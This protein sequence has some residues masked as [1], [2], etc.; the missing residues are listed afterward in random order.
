M[1]SYV[2]G[3]HNDR[4]EYHNAAAG[5]QYTENDNSAGK[6]VVTETTVDEVAWYFVER[7][8]TT[9]SDKPD[10]LH[11]FYN[12]KSQFVCGKE[13]DVKPVI[14][15]RSS[16]QEQIKEL[17]FQGSKVRVSN[18]DTQQSQGESIVIQVI[19]EMFTDGVLHKF[20]QTFVLARQAQGWYVLNDILRYLNDEEEQEAALAADEAT[21]AV[22]EEPVV[23][24]PQVE[25]PAEAPKELDTAEVYK[26]LESVLASEPTVEAPVTNGN[27][28]AP[29]AD[30]AEEAPVAE[31]KPEVSVT[32]EVAEQQVEEEIAKQEE[33]P[34]APAATPAV[35][36]PP[37]KAMP[38]AP[39][40]PAAPP[41][42]MTWASRAAAGISTAKPAPVVPAKAA[43][44][45]VQPRAAPPSATP[46]APAASATAPSAPAEKESAAQ[47][48]WQTAGSD[49]K[50]PRA[51]ATPA[52]KDS[53]TLG[54]I[55]NVTE[56]VNVDELK[57]TLSKYG[58]LAY[59][60]V[61]PAK[62]C[63]FVEFR[64][65]AGYRAAAAANPHVLGGEN[66]IVELRRPKAAAYG[67]SGYGNNHPR[68]GMSNRGRGSFDP[69]RSGSQGGG[70]GG[71]GSRGRGAAGASRG[72]G[73]RPT[74]QTT[75]A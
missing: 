37:P 12:K 40:Q 48:G 18:V 58:E 2:N 4:Q 59:F 69:G 39:V 41:K 16:I 70:R 38:V 60:D 63:A 45:P 24:E 55:R 3:T 23:E 22:A 27:G 8:Y 10:Q 74:G 73:Q 64:D 15:G 43:T 32:P 56:K 50:R 7:Y 36:A 51:V 54:Y 13:N 20:V 65:A 61:N 9:L 47:S 1:A 35:V 21:P 26:E 68:G 71:F 19:G 75:V 72:N 57:A 53:E 14:L 6:S 52:V 67:G 49:Q 30:E 5:A 31:T 62:N 44:P 46:T 33:K 25:E 29:E 34:Q 28:I 17:L 42:P 11:L 66:V